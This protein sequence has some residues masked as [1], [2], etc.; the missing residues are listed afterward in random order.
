MVSEM[1]L[2][3]AKAMVESARCGGSSLVA[4]KC[5]ARGCQQVV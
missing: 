4:I 1:S 5:K 3:E 2:R